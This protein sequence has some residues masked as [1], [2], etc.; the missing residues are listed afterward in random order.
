MS[1]SA[2]G[3]RFDGFSE[4]TGAILFRGPLGANGIEFS[5][6]LCAEQFKFSHG[7]LIRFRSGPFKDQVVT[8]VG[9]REGCLWVYSDADAC[10]FEV[11]KCRTF[12]Q[13]LEAHDPTLADKAALRGA[14]REMKGP[15]GFSYVFDAAHDAI[16]ARFGVTPGAAVHLAMS[17]SDVVVVGVLFDTLWVARADAPSVAVPLRGV[18]NEK[19]LIG[20]HGL[21]SKD[22]ISGATT[23]RAP[24]TPGRASGGKPFA[25]NAGAGTAKCQ[26]AF[27]NVVEVRTTADALAAFGVKHAQRMMCLSGS[28]IGKTATVV[29][30]HCGSLHV[31]IDGDSRVTVCRNCS[32]ASSLADMFGFDVA[33]PRQQSRGALSP[34]PSGTRSKSPPQTPR[35][36][37][38]AVPRACWTAHGRQ[39]FDVST[40]ACDTFGLRHGQS[41][42]ATRGADAGTVFHCFGVRLGSM[43]VVPDGKQRA[44]A[45]RHCND[46]A[47]VDVAYG[48]VSVGDCDLSHMSAVV[49]EPPPTPLASPRGAASP[50]SSSPR[51]AATHVLPRINMA[52][53]QGAASPM[54]PPKQSAA[55]PSPVRQVDMGSTPQGA[56]AAA[57]FTAGQMP[58][59]REYLKAYALFMSQRQSQSADPLAF[60]RYYT[61]DPQPR[62]ANAMSVLGA[63]ASHWEAQERPARCAFAAAST[64]DMLDAMRGV[65]HLLA[66]SR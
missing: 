17:K 13:L 27:G 48:F 30:I 22:P 3:L 23:P 38:G 58:A 1:S 6:Q 20:L 2:T 56:A 29:G 42:R 4:A 28:T 45:L 64:D 21:S 10:A 65:P 59:T 51:D 37:P 39:H 18:T 60:Q 44:T 46:K 55:S 25:V 47:A 34:S 62:I 11:P 24:V 63:F 12:G 61:A 40:A 33:P 49:S 19:Q 35:S 9:V 31:H 7:D 52:A 54:T 41:V 57:P 14:R 8:V 50:L 66:V 5:A 32:D 15:L 43:W 36:K 53:L 26:M 16:E